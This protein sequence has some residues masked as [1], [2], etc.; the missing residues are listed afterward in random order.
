MARKRFNS[1]RT[2]WPGANRGCARGAASHR[3]LG[4]MGRASLGRV[5]QG[6]I[7]PRR[8]RAL[9]KQAR[10]VGCTFPTCSPLTSEG[11]LRR[12]R[13]RL[14]AACTSPKLDRT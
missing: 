12:L 3:S 11:L 2:G 6:I 5:G 13:T 9:R 14:S 4:R 8:R 1:L 7:G 10:Q